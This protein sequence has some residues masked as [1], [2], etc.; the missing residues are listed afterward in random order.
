MTYQGQEYA[1]ALSLTNDESVVFSLVS[2]VADD[3]NTSEVVDAWHYDGLTNGAG[4][5]QGVSTGVVGG[6]FFNNNALA[7]IGNGTVRWRSDGVAD[8][9]YQGKDS[10]SYDG[11]SNGLFQLSVDF[12]D[13]DFTATSALSNGTGRVNYGIKDGSGN[14]AYF[15]LT[16][17]SG[18]GSNAQYRLEVKDALNNNLNVASFSGTT[19]D[20]LAVRAV[21]DLAASGSAGSFKVYYRKNGAS[22]V[23]A[24]T[25]QLVAGFA[26][27]QLRAVVQTYNG[28]ANWAAGDQLF[29]DNLVLRKLGDPP[30]PPSET[31]IDGWY[32][33]GLANGAGLSEALSVGAV[34]GAAFGDDAIVS[35]SNNA[36]RWAWDGA[37]PS[38]FKTTAPSSQ[39]GATS[40]LFQVGWDYVSADFANTDAADGSANIGFGIR[41]EADGNQDAAFRLRYDGTANEFLLQLTDANGANQTLATFAGNQLTNLSVR[42]VLDLDSRGAAGSLKL[43]YTPNGGGEMAGTVAGMLHP[44]FRIDLLRYAVQT[45]NGGTAWAL[46]DAAITDNLVFSLLTATA[47]PAS[48]YEDWLADYPSVGST[49]IEDNLLFYAFGANPTNPATTGN[50]PEY[51]VVEGGL[52][53]V[54]YERNDA[55]ARGLGYVVET[56]GDLSGSWT[57]GGFVFVGAGGS[58]A[59]FNVVTNRL[60]VAAGAG[61]IRVN[62]EYNP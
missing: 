62:V 15:R 20:H 43:F 55:E 33:D 18:G 7:S 1:S 45:T 44:L 27:D 25:G 41:S 35:I 9:M 34:G 17:V 53:Y 26:L 19:L 11:A 57:N 40:G 59:A 28:G 60:P 37:D 24:H 21:Y 13:A 6:V 32:F 3:P 10:S 54:H 22:E 31:V 46:G 14:D 49:N 52:E 38:A 58:G 12:L 61:F 29:T 5:A 4:L 42:M 39:A 56:T 50:W 2:S 36:T 51:Q 48:L 23:L 47:T 8:S 16:F 30:P